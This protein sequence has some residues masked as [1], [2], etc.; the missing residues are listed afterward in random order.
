MEASAAG[1]AAG[2]EDGQADGAAAAAG[3]QANAATLAAFQESLNSGL[4]AQQEAFRDQLQEFATQQQQ[5]PAAEQ[6]QA[7]QPDLGFLGDPDPA[8]A[9]QGLQEFMAGVA[10]AQAQK[11]IAEAVAPLNQQVSDMKL[12]QQSAALVS[13]IPELGK[14]EVAQPV[15]DEAHR[16]A[17]M[18]GHPELVANPDF[19]K[20]IYFSQRAQQLAAQQQAGAAGGSG[21]ATL[22]GAGGASPGGAQQGAE[23]TAESMA[24]KWGG[25]S[26]VLSKL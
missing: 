10:D 23:R 25:R 3:E 26:D 18:L 2:G 17:T 4:S 5:Q 15:V 19:I 16:Q 1:L 22:E 6:E 14:A 21:V 12:E 9:A 7:P 11:A 13:E 8:K 24:A 20:T